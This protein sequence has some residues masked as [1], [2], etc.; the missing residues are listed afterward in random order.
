PTTNPIGTGSARF[1]AR[2]Q[3]GASNSEEA[4]GAPR[5]R[6]P[7]PHG[8]TRDRRLG[9]LQHDPTT[10]AASP[11]R[12]ETETANSRHLLRGKPSQ[13]RNAPHP[14]FRDAGQ[15]IAFPWP[16]M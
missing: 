14:N 2:G 7:L 12:L 4:L 3:K 1:P 6:R 15:P 10:K 13:D 5:A 9:G 16:G 11:T 8:V